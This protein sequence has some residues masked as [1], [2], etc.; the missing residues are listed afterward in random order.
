MSN[1]PLGNKYALAALREKRAT[2][3]GELEL[4]K[5]Q[6]TWKQTQLASVDDTLTLFDASLLPAP[7]G[8]R[9]PTSA[10]TCSNKVN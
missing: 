2:L 10:S 5:R 4:L 8:Q 7:S 1:S 6:V 3:A 9:S